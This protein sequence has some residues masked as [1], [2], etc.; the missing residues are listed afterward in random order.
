MPD[1]SLIGNVT[2]SYRAPGDGEEAPV[3]RE[4]LSEPLAAGRYYMFPVRNN[5]VY[6]SGA[7]N[8]GGRFQY[9][10]GWT[11]QDYLGQAGDRPGTAAR[12]F[13]Y[14]SRPAVKRK[15]D[16]VTEYIREMRSLFRRSSTRSVTWRWAPVCWVL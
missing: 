12:K 14:A 8:G 16:Q 10:P 5:W 3:T 9:R 15:P 2:Y 7:I 11:V 6:V 13:M 1:T 4:M